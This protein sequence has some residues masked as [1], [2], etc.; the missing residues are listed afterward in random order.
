MN[1]SA[2]GKGSP[3]SIRAGTERDIAPL[4]QAHRLCFPED[5]WDRTTLD[6]LFRLSGYFLRLAENARAEPEAPPA[7][8]C[9]ARTAADEAEVIT[10][11]VLPQSRRMGLGL[12]L[13][14]D[15]CAQARALG[16]RQLFL[17][18]AEDNHSALALY[19]SGE[20]VVTARRPAYYDRGRRTPV[21]ALVM[22][23]RIY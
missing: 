14:A 6:A 18:V 7:G 20:F 13:L 19:R 17:E 10:L 1:R 5:P 21:D 8:F 4:A 23:R 2:E 15:V 9:L 3:H 16:A 12:T 11:G 22:E